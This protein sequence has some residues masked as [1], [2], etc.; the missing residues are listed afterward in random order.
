MGKNRRSFILV[1][2]MLI[3]LQVA[4]QAVPPPIPPPPPPGLSLG[5]GEYFFLIVGLIFGIVEVRKG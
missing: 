4:G 1:A 5:V 2:L 3:S